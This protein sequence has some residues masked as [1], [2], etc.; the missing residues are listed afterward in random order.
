MDIK[1]SHICKSFDQRVL[2]DD[3]CLVFPENSISCLTGPSGCGKT[4]V[5]NL[6]MGLQ[7]PDSGKISGAEEARISAVFQE[8]RLCENLS[9][10]SNACIALSKSQTKATASTMLCALG[11]SD[12]LHRPVNALS[13]G[14]K[15]RVALARALLSDYDLL[16]LDEPFS[17]LD[18]KNSAQAL[19]C[20][21]AN[22]NNRTAILISHTPICF[23]KIDYNIYY[24]PDFFKNTNVK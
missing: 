4:T 19:D 17:G 5:L 1:F 21:Q 10:L 18:A 24:L 20:L 15:R 22:L 9:V 13:G 2:F 7:T 12:A 14:M 3:L 8:D 16:L 11:L 23:Q 6:L